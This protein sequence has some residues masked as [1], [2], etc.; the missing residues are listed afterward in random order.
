MIG[1]VILTIS[2]QYIF[3]KYFYKSSKVMTKT[4]K[5]GKRIKIVQYITKSLR[6]KN[7]GLI[8]E[9]QRWLKY[10]RWQPC[11][12]Y[13]IVQNDIHILFAYV[14]LVSFL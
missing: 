13:N 12:F 6:K 14:D 2:F 11:M 9:N 3:S 1:L 4:L 10:S 7:I 5:S 8:N